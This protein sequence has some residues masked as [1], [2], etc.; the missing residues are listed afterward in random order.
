MIEFRFEYPHHGWSV[1]I[2]FAEYFD[3]F[4]KNNKD[5]QVSY[6]NSSD[7]S[8]R[9]GG[10]IN[11]AHIMTI[12]NTLN[13][14]YLIIS[15][16]DNVYDLM[17][18]SNGWNPN[19]CVEIITSSGVNGCKNL[20]PFSYL[21]YT[22]EF[23]D[24]SKNAKHMDDK[25]NNELFFKGFLYGDRL[26][27]KNCGKLNISD[28]KIH[29]TIKYFEELTNNK[30]CLSLNG[31]GEICNRDIEILSARSV[32]L[33]PKISFKFHNELIPNYHYISFEKTYDP[34]IQSDIILE[35][36][37]SIKNDKDY[38]K[39]ISEN[40]YK[41]FLENGTIESHVKMLKNIINI[42]KLYG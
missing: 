11:S 15:Y 25:Q 7:F 35:K 1:P 18:E 2:V 27:L 24:L 10:G 31:A 23:E 34:K 32:L 39:Y 19:D 22:I 17:L 9:F 6:I 8:N 5:I 16:W 38:L 30:I 36:Y 26:Q 42:E 33:R 4:K 41:W 40:G 37:E 20:T 12:K 13:G 29:P 21:P 3:D 28:N 14:K